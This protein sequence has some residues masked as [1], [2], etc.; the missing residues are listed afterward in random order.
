MNESRMSRTSQWV[1]NEWVIWW[2]SQRC[3]THIHVWH[4]WV[5]SHRYDI[6]L[7]DT[8]IVYMSQIRAMFHTYTCLTYVSH[9]SQIWYVSHRYRYNIFST[10]MSHVSHIYTSRVTLVN[11]S[12]HIYMSHRCES[13][14]TQSYLQLKGTRCGWFIQSRTFVYSSTPSPPYSWWCVTCLYS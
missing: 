13:C 3:L 11:E 7:T 10:G 2:M 6:C 8:D 9:V 12:C 1:T 14:L 4:I 5:T